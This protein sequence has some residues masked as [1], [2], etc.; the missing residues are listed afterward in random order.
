VSASMSESTSASSETHNHPSAI[1]PMR[2]TDCGVVVIPSPVSERSRSET[3]TVLFRAPGTSPEDL[4]PACCTPESHG[5][6][7]VPGARIR[8][9]RW[10]SQVNG[11][12]LL[13][14]V[15]ANPLV[16]V[17]SRPDTVERCTRNPEE[18]TSSSP[19]RAHGRDGIHGATFPRSS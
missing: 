8:S 5:K 7:V 10:H 2:T 11:A 9:N 17:A 12:V 4:P 1:E 13:M 16:S 19:W 6:A 14:S 18:A 15:L 3:R